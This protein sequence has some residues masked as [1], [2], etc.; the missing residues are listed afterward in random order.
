[1]SVSILYYIVHPVLLLICVVTQFI[2]MFFNVI[3]PLV[4]LNVTQ[5]IVGKILNFFSEVVL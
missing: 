5:C 1:M 3:C 4:S 2:G